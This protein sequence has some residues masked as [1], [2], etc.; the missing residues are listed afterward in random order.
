MTALAGPLT[1]PS[2]L[3]AADHIEC[4]DNLDFMAGLESESMKL[5]VTSPPYNIGKAYEK[6][7]SLDDYVD[8]LAP[9]VA[10]CVRLLPGTVK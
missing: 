6:R 7:T 8:S 10:Q 3:M 2:G 5:I 9:V 1:A 4:Q